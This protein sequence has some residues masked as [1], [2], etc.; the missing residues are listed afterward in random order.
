[1][2][3]CCASGDVDRC[4]DVSTASKSLKTFVPRPLMVVLPV[5]SAQT[6]MFL[7]MSIGIGKQRTKI[8]QRLGEKEFIQGMKILFTC[9][10]DHLG[11]E[12]S[13]GLLRLQKER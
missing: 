6:T 2:A 4:S 10:S 5:P 11:H 12:L 8:E 9:P 13:C 1:M 7:G 3:A